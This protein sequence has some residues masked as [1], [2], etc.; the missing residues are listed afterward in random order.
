M[1][2]LLI[3]WVCPSTVT[4]LSKFWP[5]QSTQ[6]EMGEFLKVKENPLTPVSG[7]GRP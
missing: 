4:T 2:F 3:I 1:I 6:L 7:V 5:R